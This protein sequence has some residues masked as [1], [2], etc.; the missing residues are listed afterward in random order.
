MILNVSSTCPNAVE[1][2]FSEFGGFLKLNVPANASNKIL[3]ITGKWK[4]TAAMGG[5]ALENRGTCGESSITIHEIQLF[6]GSAGCKRRKNLNLI[7]KNMAFNRSALLDW[8]I[9][10]CLKFC[11]YHS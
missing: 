3:K 7:M 10:F 4:V 2:G 8:N 6:K 1:I 11:A 9:I 5:T